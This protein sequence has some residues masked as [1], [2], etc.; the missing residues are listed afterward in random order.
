MITHLTNVIIIHGLSLPW[1]LSAVNCS[2]SV[3]RCDDSN[4]S[5]WLYGDNTPI[6]FSWIPGIVSLSPIIALP[7]SHMTLT[8]TNHSAPSQSHD[9]NPPI[10]VLPHSHMTLIH[11]SQPSPPCSN[12][13]HTFLTIFVSITLLVPGPVPSLC[14]LPLVRLAVLRYTTLETRHL[15]GGLLSCDC[16]GGL[17]LVD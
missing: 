9:T 13:S 16:E 7:Y 15:I 3:E 11:Q 8:P 14:S 17:W 1:Y 10:T 5:C 4:F 2:I 12:A 6:S